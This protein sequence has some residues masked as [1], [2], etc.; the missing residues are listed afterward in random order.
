MIVEICFIIIALYCI[1]VGIYVV[2]N[3][4]GI[5]VSIVIK[6]PVKTEALEL[7]YDDIIGLTSKKSCQPLPISAKERHDVKP[8]KKATIFAP[9]KSIEEEK[10]LP[11]SVT[12]SDN[13]TLKEDV[14]EMFGISN[15]PINIDCEREYIN[16]KSINLDEEDELIDYDIDPSHQA[17]AVMY[18]EVDFAYGV[19]KSDSSTNSEKDKAGEVFNRL[20]GSDMIEQLQK[21]SKKMDESIGHL[22]SHHL[23][24]YYQS[25]IPKSSFELPDNI[26]NFDICDFV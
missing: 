9:D 23:K 16:D 2:V 17:Q 5:S 6:R 3:L 10:P 21:E 19:V 26:A 11:K 13:S 15:K 4:M 25:T 24:R 20:A 8:E 12:Y 14:D 18:E 7:K 1:I 22:L